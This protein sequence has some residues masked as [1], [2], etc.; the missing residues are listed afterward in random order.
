M[1]VKVVKSF[2][3]KTADLVTR[4]VDDEFDVTE[5]RAEEL[6]KGGY[7]EKVED[8]SALNQTPP[9]SDEDPGDSAEEPT[10]NSAEDTTPEPETKPEPKKSS[11]A[12]KTE[13]KD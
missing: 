13:K 3:D 10:E 12:K 8:D 1:K 9:E 7:V 2:N 4:V 11:K 5:Q 6:I